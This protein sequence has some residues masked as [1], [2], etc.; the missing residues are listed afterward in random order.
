MA[1]RIDLS[2]SLDGFVTTTDATSKSPFGLDWGRLV[3]AYTTTFRS[4]NASPEEALALSRQAA[5]GKDIRVGGGPTT[6]R[7][8]LSA[9]L[10][11]QL[12]VGVPPILLGRGMRLWDDLRGLENGCTVTRETAE[13]GTIHLSYRR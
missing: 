2:I 4:V 3:E 11:D 12:H 8:F 13:S 6:A 5:G 10:V 7:D 1:A 9:R